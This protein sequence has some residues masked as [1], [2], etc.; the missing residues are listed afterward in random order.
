MLGWR[1]TLRCAD[2]QL[3]AFCFFALC[4]S[5]KSPSLVWRAVVRQE[6][7]CKQLWSPQCRITLYLSALRNVTL[8]SFQ[9]CPLST[10]ELC[11]KVIATQNI[12]NTVEYSPGK[13][14]LYRTVATSIATFIVYKVL[15]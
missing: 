12:Q 6:T 14:S 2:D 5:L 3:G 13:S 8:P 9:L 15:R 1:V 4:S 11:W 10:S 7:S